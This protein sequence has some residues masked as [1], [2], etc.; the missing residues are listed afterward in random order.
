MATKCDHSMGRMIGFGMVSEFGTG[1]V[2]HS[3]RD[4]EWKCQG[5]GAPEENPLLFPEMWKLPVQTGRNRR[6]W[7]GANGAHP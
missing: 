1:K 7:V 4:S 3:F 6:H 5:C 2:L